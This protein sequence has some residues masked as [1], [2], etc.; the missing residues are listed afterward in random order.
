MSPPVPDRHLPFRIRYEV[1][2]QQD[3]T[4][5]LSRRRQRRR[6]RRR[7]PEPESDPDLHRQ[8]DRRPQRPGD[9]ARRR[10]V[11][12]NNQGNA[13]PFYNEGDNGEN[14]ARKGVA[15]TENLDRYTRKAI[16]TFPNGYTAF[17]GQRDDGFY[18]DVQSIFDLLKLRNPGKDAQGGFNIHMMALRIPL[19]ELGGDKQTVGVF[20]TTGR[21][22]FP[23][24]RHRPQ[25]CP[26]RLDPPQILAYQV[27]RQGNPLFVEGLMALEDKDLYNRTLPNVDSKVFRKYAESP[28]LA[29]LINLLIG[30]GQQLAIPRGA[31]TWRRSSTPT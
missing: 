24:Q 18:A 8:K 25:S 28:E 3:A 10:V 2:K 26:A 23:V 12:P 13:T 22:V 5:I 7:R 19:S 16:F 4:P 30:G 15:K 11:P 31:P 21:S 20:G 17:A 14:P 9:D 1:Q 27:A 6:R 29:T